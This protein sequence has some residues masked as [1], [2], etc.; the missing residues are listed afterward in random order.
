MILI[1]SREDDSL[2]PVFQPA[3]GSGSMQVRPLFLS[4]AAALAAMGTC[5]FAQHLP[6]NIQQ[7]P[8]IVQGT[9]IAPGSVPFHLKATITAGNDPSPMAT[10]EMDWDAPDRWQRTID[11]REFSQ[12]LIVNG[13]KV[14]EANTGSYF[15]L[16]LQ[17]LVTAMIDP[18]PLLDAYRPGD[19]LQTKA[20]GASDESGRTCYDT[21]RKICGMGAFGLHESVGAAGHS[22]DL[23]SYKDF[24]GKRIAHRLIYTA[25]PGSYLTAEV[26]DLTRLYRPDA[27]LFAI[28]QPTAPE[29]KIS[30]VILPEAELR[31]LAA[32]QPEIIWPQVL[33]GAATGKASF[34]VSL[35]REGK[36]RE[37]LP[38][39][40]ANERS[41]DSA[42]R[43]ILRLRFKPAVKDGLAVQAEG[44]LTFD[45]NTRAS[46]PANALTDVEV[47]KL[48][49]NIVAPVVA[50][51]T[52]PPG[53]VYKMLLSVDS[54][55]IVIE[56]L[57]G[58]GP[59][60]LFEACDQ[61][62]KQW[63]FSPIME[64][65]MSRPYRAQVVF[66]F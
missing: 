52:V 50:P 65:G 15:P 62:V 32:E 45:L 59:A 49:T 61:A 42:I 7:N 46:G 9:L 5:S 55:G 31:G 37:A 1:K 13:D 53:T 24:H 35:D 16:G 12:T 20:N 8:K 39:K 38:L 26:T 43:Q 30:S 14:F 10:V 36:V 60:Q 19:M 22:V 51:G 48:A 40:T 3:Q 66:H 25:W 41:N 21:D 47:R 2:S 58:E 56:K 64:N 33:D 54:D 29:M 23:M 6:E 18:K 34:Y 44:I 28:S 17:T 57:P 4:V 11:S 27:S 63:R